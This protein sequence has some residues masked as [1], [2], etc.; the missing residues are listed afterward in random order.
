[1]FP[2]LERWQWERRVPPELTARVPKWIPW[3]LVEPHAARARKNHGQTLEQLA[4]RGGLS[5]FELWC[6]IHDADPYMRL[7]EGGLEVMR[8]TEA[9]AAAWLVEAVRP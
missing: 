9:E 3:A 6:V 4:A 1:M 8:V 5:P 7:P 2:V